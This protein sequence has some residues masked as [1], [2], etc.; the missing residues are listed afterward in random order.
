MKGARYGCPAVANCL[1]RIILYS[2]DFEIDL[3]F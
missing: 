1:S 3:K 2:T